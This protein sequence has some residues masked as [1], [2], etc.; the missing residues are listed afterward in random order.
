MAARKFQVCTVL[1]EII[2]KKLGYIVPDAAA[3]NV[4]T[5]GN[6]NP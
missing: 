5:R 1:V 6:P 3:T 4:Y 2:I